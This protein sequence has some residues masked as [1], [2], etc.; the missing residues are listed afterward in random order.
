MYEAICHGGP[1][2]GQHAI[3]RRPAGFL[4]VDRPAGQCWIYDYRADA[5]FEVRTPDGMPVLTTGPRGRH[6]AAEEGRYDVLAAPWVET[7]A[8]FDG[9]ARQ[10]GG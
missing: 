8:P 1:L 2:D 6:R 9:G 7:V 3:S 10:P 4:L 5:G